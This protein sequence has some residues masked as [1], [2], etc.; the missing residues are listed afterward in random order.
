MVA[1]HREHHKDTGDQSHYG[2]DAQERWTLCGLPFHDRSRVVRTHQYPRESLHGHD[3]SQHAQS[4]WRTRGCGRQDHD[5]P[6]GNANCA[7]RIE[8]YR[9]REVQPSK[10][11]PALRR[12]QAAY[13]Y[14]NREK[15]YEQRGYPHTGIYRSNAT[16]SSTLH[17]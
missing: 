2:T 11:S 7:S 6:H 5:E 13:P 12:N 15:R 4:F 1:R 8:S 17:T 10:F 3:G 14:G 16:I 9:R